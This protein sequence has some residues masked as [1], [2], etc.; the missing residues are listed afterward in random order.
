MLENR[1]SLNLYMLCGGTNFGFFNGANAS[2]DE[3][4]APVT[5]SYD[6]LAAIDEAG[7]PREKYFAF[8]D[9]IA[10]HRRIV[11]RPVPDL[12]EVIAVP[13]C[14]LD[15]SA[16]LDDVLGQPVDSKRPL[17]MERCNQSFGY[18]LYRTILPRSG[19]GLLEIDELRDYATVLLD[20][21]IFGYL[22][23]RLGQNS[24]RIDVR[25]EN[26]TLELLVENCGRVNYGPLMNG[27]RKG[28]TRR[29]RWDGEELLGWQIF[30]L[31]F[32]DL[33]ALHFSRRKRAAPAFHRGLLKLRTAGDTFLDTGSLGKGFIFINGRNAGRYWR[34]GPQRSLYIPGTWLR[35]G[36]NE[37]IT[38]DIT[39]LDA[40]T[41]SGTNDPERPTTAG[42]YCPRLGA[43]NQAE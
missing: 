7:R 41:V 26:A 37:I 17:P 31:P 27:E 33:P 42:V 2:A 25:K 10:R 28:I 19:A 5:T 12:P 20:G 30:S 3:A 29:V 32:D 18:I 39:T 40:P 1:C 11:P 4:Y 13:P 43:D 8:R 22:D 14:T 24:I 15:E 36:T 16:P 35:K 9:A 38:F 6:Y 23:R 21:E 34:I